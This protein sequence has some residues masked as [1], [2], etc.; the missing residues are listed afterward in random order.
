M[1]R[2]F[3]AIYDV[4][5]TIDEYRNRQVICAASGARRRSHV[6]ARHA[7]GHDCVVR[8]Q[9]DAVQEPCRDRVHER[10]YAAGA[11]ESAAIPPAGASTGPPASRGIVKV[12]EASGSTPTTLML[13]PNTLPRGQEGP[14]VC[15][16][17]AG[18]GSHE[19]T[20]L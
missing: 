19:R 1:G 16:L 18:G 13:L 17:A 5:Y 14:R 2:G 4:D 11:R 3:S 10:A 15:R 12:G 6:T 20:R 8:N 9:D 7:A